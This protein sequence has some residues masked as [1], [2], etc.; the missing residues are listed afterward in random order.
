MN[1]FAIALVGFVLIHV[2]VAATGLR[3]ALVSRIGERPYRGVFSLA[4]AVFLIWM[5]WSFAKMRADPYDPL[6]AL[7]WL[8]PEW[9]IWPAYGL[10]FLG[11]V[12]IVAGSLTPGPTY[13]GFEGTLNNPEPA[14]GMLRITRNP[15]LWGVTLWGLGHL[16]VNGERYAI[17]LFG[18]LA[19]MTLFGS[20]SIDRK[21]AARNPE[22]WAR[23]AAVTSNVPLL[24]IVQG[25]NK[26]IIGEI[27]WRLIVAVLA[28]VLFGY[29][30]QVIIGVPAF[31]TP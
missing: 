20:R 4:S 27:G 7:V 29:F 24:A 23:F 21:G 10:I 5:I 1:S 9:L 25:R 11:F 12:F 26:L 13:V 16:L 19:L 17:M 6:N 15:F 28:F 2:G 8:P 18:A 14:K 30:H 31:R 22:G 3:T